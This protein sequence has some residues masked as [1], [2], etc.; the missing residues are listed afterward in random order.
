MEATWT[1]AHSKSMSEF[2]EAVSTIA[3]PGLNIVYADAQ[4]N[5]AWYTAA[6]FVIRPEGANASLLQ[7]GSGAND[8]IGYHDFYVN[9]KQENPE[10]GFVLTANNDPQNDT[11]NLFPG[12]YVPKDRYVRLRNLLFTKSKFNREDL[13]RI[14]I[15][16]KNPVAADIAKTLVSKLSGVCIVKTQINERAAMM[17]KNWDGDHK[18]TDNAPVIY[19]KFLYHVMSE[20]MMD[21][22]GEKDFELFLKTHVQKIML[23]NF[24][25]NDSSV[26]WDNKNTFK[27][28]TQNDIIEKA[29]DKTISELVVQLGFNPEKWTWGKVHTIEFEHPLGK[30]KPLDK[31]F[32][33]GP[34]SEMG[35]METVNNQSF[36]LN[37]KGIYKVNL[38]PALRRVIDFA[39]PES[40]YSINPSGQSGNFISRHY[41]NQVKLYISGKYRKELMNFDEVKRLSK[42]IVYFQPLD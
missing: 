28:E 35:G 5:I 34:F 9:P 30:Q 20:A 13:E 8:W 17:L 6:K 14:A 24:F 4:N 16:V 12:Y 29:F 40:A 18:V 27:K 3:A 11:T 32:N 25:N 42:D 37:G 1:M 10:L 26:W 41:S 15:D 21:E 36:D 38:G 22:L 19:Y 23:A 39:E 31:I 7:D 2:R 33:I